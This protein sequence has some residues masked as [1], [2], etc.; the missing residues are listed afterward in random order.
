MR[1]MMAAVVVAVTFSTTTAP[2]AGAP[3]V[4]EPRSR[5]ACQVGES[6]QLLGLSWTCAK[7][8]GATAFVA[9][10]AGR[11]GGIPGAPGRCSSGDWVQIGSQRLECRRVGARTTWTGARRGATAAQADAWIQQR[12]A[13]ITGSCK[14]TSWVQLTAGIKVSCLYGKGKEAWS[15][16]SR[17]P[18]STGSGSAPL[19]RPE[20]ANKTTCLNA[21]WDREFATEIP[22]L[23]RKQDAALTER[24]WAYCH[25]AYT[26]FMTK[27]ERD[28][29]YAQYFGQLGQ[30][31]ADEVTRVS[32]STGMNPCQAV[33][34]VLR[35]RY[36]PGFGL[37]GWDAQGYLP[38]LYKQWQNGP[39]LGKLGGSVDNCSN[40]K[41]SVQFRRH[42]NATHEGPYYPARGTADATFPFSE[43][44]M[45][46][47]K[48]DAATCL[49][50]SP[51]FGNTSPGSAA[52]VIGYNFTS[53]GDGNNFVVADNEVPKCE[54]RAA[55]AAGLPVV[56]QPSPS[57]SD[58][59][60]VA[61]DFAGVWHM[62]DD[63]CSW[64]LKPANG[65]PT[66]S[67]TPADGPYMS[68]ALEPGDQF[69]STCRFQKTDWEHMIVAPDGLMPLQT[70]A[71]GPR[72]PSTP[73][74]CR[75]A[76]TDRS[77]LRNP[78][79]VSALKTYAG[80]TVTFDTSTGTDGIGALLRGVGCGTWSLV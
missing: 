64:T 43:F 7:V 51:I 52:K 19:K 23:A 2:A 45:G 74:T 29:A 42:Y 33:D 13:A 62:M 76:I 57:A 26:T 18:A 66:V 22:Q 24:I 48:V 70:L 78:P 4:P 5:A 44:D 68:V 36:A 35:P 65:A 21:W 69:A 9:V 15:A 79:P 67:W 55:Q 71:P 50:W 58:L 37:I 80:E 6:A 73:A 75:Y 54:F 8:G 49:V 17:P 39:I 10:G 56:W 12:P 3:I 16:L 61:N 60:T 25:V 41:I 77:A 72:R 34:A 63:N 14:G 27:A 46:I 11:G 38:I 32:A 30:L 53:R 59:R 31:V 1:F 20:G 40:G 28:A 47:S